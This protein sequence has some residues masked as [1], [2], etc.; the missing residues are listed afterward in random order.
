MNEINLC[1]LIMAGGKGTRLWPE[2]VSS[3]PKQ[4][5]K[6]LG[7]D[8]LIKGTSNRLEGLISTENRFVVTVK[9]QEAIAK[10]CLGE[11]VPAQNYIYE[12]KGRNTAPCIFLSLAQMLADPNRNPDDVVAILPSDH[13]ILNKE[14]FQNTL[15]IAFDLSV[16]M[17]TIVTIGIKP[18]F[19][20]TGFGYIKAN[21][22]IEKDSFTV[23]AFKEKPDFQT[24]KEYVESGKYFWNAGM[25]VGQI[26]TL[27]EE[28]K[29]YC[30]DYMTEL[31][32][33][34]ENVSNPD[35]LIKVYDRLK[36]ISV[37]YAIM[38]K[39]KRINVVQAQFDWNDLGSWD[40]MES[41]IER[42]DDN[43][44][45]KAK[46][47]KQVGSKNNIVFAPDHAVALVDV[48]D[49]VVV[50]NQKVVTVIKKQSAQKIKEIVALY[51][52]TDLV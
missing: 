48:E 5:L 26:S 9:E 45:I 6:L 21:E 51:K 14:G 52:D 41:V 42:E 34:K 1:A 8:S 13:I 20:H 3:R 46:D 17:K 11:A 30:P 49:L 25:F 16:R 19:P 2:S 31:K 27:L 23:E 12:P 36:A 43:F 38:E 29:A 40:A 22:V 28:F 7:E 18:H 15:K 32:N 4:Y 44:T 33:L 35:E 10:E 24:A 37:D 39:S 47:I 50:A